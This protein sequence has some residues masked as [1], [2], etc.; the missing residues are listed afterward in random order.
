[1]LVRI[2]LRLERCVHHLLE[3]RRRQP[4]PPLGQGSVRDGLASKLF[5]MLGQC[6]SLG[7][8]MEDQALDLRRYMT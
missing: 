4:R 8:D 6:T 1:M 5:H 2:G 3:S 7:E